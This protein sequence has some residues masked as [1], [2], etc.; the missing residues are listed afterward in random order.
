MQ[1]QRQTF[2]QDKEFQ[3]VN[4]WMWERIQRQRVQIVSWFFFWNAD[5]SAV[6][7]EARAFWAAAAG[8]RCNQSASERLNSR[9]FLSFYLLTSTQG[10]GI[11]YIGGANPCKRHIFRLF[12]VMYA[13]AWEIF[14]LYN[15]YLMKPSLQP[16]LFLYEY[17]E[18]SEDEGI[19]ETWLSFFS[20]FLISKLT[21]VWFLSSTTESSRLCLLTCVCTN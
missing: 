1:N 17:V 4:F 3:N 6:S 21:W 15:V 20:D 2:S 11:I 14:N 8:A 13:P 12:D 10:T 18:F 19:S 7:S 16:S 9:W 5:V